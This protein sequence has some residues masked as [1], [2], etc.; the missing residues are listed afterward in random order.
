MT[1]LNGNDTS[2][3]TLPYKFLNNLFPCEIPPRQEAMCVNKY[4][5]TTEALKV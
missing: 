2:Q 4:K 1:R 3:Q 5:L